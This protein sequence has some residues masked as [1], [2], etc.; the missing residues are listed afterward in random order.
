[1]GEW[2][3]ADG[4][5]G[6]CFAVRRS[7]LLTLPAPAEPSALPPRKGPGEELA[8]GALS[9][10]GGAGGVQLVLGSHKRV[11]L[12]WTPPKHSVMGG[13]HRPREE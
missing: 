9:A 2:R 12:R 5:E 11:G 13:N 6:A 10:C 3:R 7:T 4:W 8:L 1:M